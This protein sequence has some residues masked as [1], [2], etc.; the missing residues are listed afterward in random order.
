MEDVDDW[1]AIGRA[2]IRNK[3]YRIKLELVLQNIGSLPLS[4]VRIG[5]EICSSTKF[6]INPRTIK[7]HYVSLIIFLEGHGHRSQILLF[8]SYIQIF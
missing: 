3:N 8:L 2:L 1:F 7:Y 5:S 6:Q 4:F